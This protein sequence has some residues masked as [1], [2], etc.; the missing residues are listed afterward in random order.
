MTCIEAVIGGGFGCK[1]LVVIL[2]G[3]VITAGQECAPANGTSR[4]G[5]IRLK[6]VNLEET[7]QSFI[8][9]L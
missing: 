6:V 1:Q 4:L 9:T 3:A 7:R 8:I 5:V 2:Y